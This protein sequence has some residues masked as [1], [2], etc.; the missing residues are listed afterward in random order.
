LERSELAELEAAVERG[1]AT[2]VEVG[3]ALHR[4]Q[5]E[6]LYRV[7]YDTFEEYLTRRWKMS[8]QQGYRLIDAAEVATI[9]SPVGDIENEAQARELVRV[10]RSD[11]PQAVREAY[12]EVAAEGPVTSTSLR[13]KINGETSAASG[14]EPNLTYWLGERVGRKIADAETGLGRFLERDLVRVDVDPN[15][16]R[17]AAEYAERCDLLA[18]RLREIAERA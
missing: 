18:S 3:L 6:R 7:D 12:A 5:V 13:R 17:I 1:L 14:G 10:L 8:R 4:I 9:V 15:T 16:R 2:F 11:G